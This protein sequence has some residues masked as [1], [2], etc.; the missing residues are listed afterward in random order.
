M[1]KR[2]LALGLTLVLA[3]LAAAQIG[4]QIGGS[5]SSIAF[6]ANGCVQM[7]AN[8][9]DLGQ[10]CVATGTLTPTQVRNLNGTHITVISAPAAGTALVFESAQ[11]MLDFGGTAYDN[12]ASGEDIR[13]RYAGSGAVVSEVCDE[14]ACMNGDS[15]ADQYGIVVARSIA[16]IDLTAATGIEVEILNGEWAT[17]DDDSDGNSPIHY[18][19]RYRIVTVDIS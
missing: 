11:L 5:S 12:V 7:T 14:A 4:Y 10:W 17:T 19:I 18:L 6:P 9:E 13:F 3:S 1:P 15:G 16:G 2:W 8:S